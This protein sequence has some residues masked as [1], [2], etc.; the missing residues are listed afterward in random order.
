MLKYR[1]KKGEILRWVVVTTK[2][3]LKKEEVI[4][5][6]PIFKLQKNYSLNKIKFVLIKTLY[7]KKRQK[8]SYFFKK[9]ASF[10]S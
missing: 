3:F 7:L 8:F 9:P 4:N 6:M 1:R 2:N 10:P 5:S